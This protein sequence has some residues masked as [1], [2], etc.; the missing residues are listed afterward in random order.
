V[1]LWI[2]E[3]HVDYE[4]SDDYGRAE[5]DHLQSEKGADEWDRGGCGR[6]NVGHHTEENS[7][8]EEVSGFWNIE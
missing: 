1:C 4:N 3:A 5:K 2:A 7:Y 6:S 8:G